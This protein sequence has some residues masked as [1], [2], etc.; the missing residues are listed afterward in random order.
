MRSF[1]TIDCSAALAGGELFP[2]SGGCGGGS[3]RSETAFVEFERG[4]SGGG[5]GRAGVEL[6]VG[7]EGAAIGGASTGGAV[8]ES[9]A[10]VPFVEGSPGA[11]E[12]G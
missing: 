2:S 8:S 5:T 11:E 4:G 7:A 1:E 12:S 6:S 3:E 9:C 10:G